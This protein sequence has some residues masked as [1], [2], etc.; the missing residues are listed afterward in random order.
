MLEVLVDADKK[1][2]VAQKDQA[3][4][5]DQRKEFFLGACAAA[6]ACHEKSARL[7]YLSDDPGA[8]KAFRGRTDGA[9]C[10]A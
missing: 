4:L 8:E 1:S 6:K 5:F 3:K 9:G 2:A 10:A 7:Q